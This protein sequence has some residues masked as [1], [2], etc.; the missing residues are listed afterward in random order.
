M[1]INIPYECRRNTAFSIEKAKW[2][3]PDFYIYLNKDQY[4]L[5]KTSV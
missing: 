1:T 2:N 5:E 4:Q 3:Y